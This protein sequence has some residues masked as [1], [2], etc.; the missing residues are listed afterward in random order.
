[1]LDPDATSAM[2]PSGPAAPG[3]NGGNGNGGTVT[4]D[5]NG[6][7]ALYRATSS[8]SSDN[9]ES[10][11]GTPSSP[12]ARQK[13]FFQRSASGGSSAVAGA[14][15]TCTGATASG[16]SLSPLPGD[17][18]AMRKCSDSSQGSMGSC[19]GVASSEYLRNGACMME[20]AVNFK[21]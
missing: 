5:G 16:A 11:A 1:M 9:L 18:A 13:S 2:P 15:G 3:S 6:E 19:E 12:G 20:P 8:G 10:R 4:A 21:R 17:V 14:N 7:S